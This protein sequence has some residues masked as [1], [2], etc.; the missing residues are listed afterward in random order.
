MTKVND[1]KKPTFKK[2]SPKSAD[3]IPESSVYQPSYAGAAGGAASRAKRAFGYL[4]RML[5]AYAAALSLTLMLC[6]AFFPDISA[7]KTALITALFCC[8]FGAMCVGSLLRRIGE[9]II[10]LAVSAYFLVPY[11][12]PDFALKYGDGYTVV[13]AF[14]RLWN[15]AMARLEESGFRVFFTLT[16]E[17]P[18]DGD[19]LALIGI[20][21]VA[22]L[23]SLI[24]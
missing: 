2:S 21:I 8:F 20:S 16:Y 22:A 19:T 18:L 11:V 3:A 15:M 1:G 4:A 13:Y 24:F 6:D 5:V 23:L 14:C 9:G 17:S 7:A 12:L 10:L